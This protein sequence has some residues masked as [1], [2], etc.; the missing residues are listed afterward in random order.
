MKKKENSFLAR[1]IEKIIEI[2]LKKECNKINKININ[3]DSSNINIIK[4]SIKNIH[5]I[6]EGINYK[7]LLFDEIKLEANEV[8]ILIKLRTKELKFKKS[9]TIKFSIL[10]SENSLKKILLSDKWKWLG[11]MISLKIMNK[12]KL[13]DVKIKENK[14]E[15]KASN[16]N[17]NSHEIEKVNI[18]QKAGKIYLEKEKTN[19]LINIPIEDKIYINNVNINNDTIIIDAISSIVL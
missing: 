13:E 16:Y 11:T 14:I 5:I 4:G 6:G 17:K 1:L 3:I 12:N 2:F 19:K 18:I 9:F 15:I 10:L 7:E 8:N